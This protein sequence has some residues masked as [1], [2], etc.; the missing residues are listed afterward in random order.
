MSRTFVCTLPE[1]WLLEILYRFKPS[2]M[3]KRGSE[4]LP[5]FKN[6][7]ARLELIQCLSGDDKANFIAAVDIL[8]RWTLQGDITWKNPAILDALN[9]EDA[10]ANDPDFRK[11]LK[12]V[13][14]ITLSL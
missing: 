1:K 12:K 10:C 13:E 14:K 6:K 11:A 8:R 3:H 9:W 4:T 2:F 5:E 7:A